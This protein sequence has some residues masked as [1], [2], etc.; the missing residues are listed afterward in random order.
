[1]PAEVLAE[2]DR[3]QCA[4][5]HVLDPGKEELAGR[6][7]RRVQ[8]MFDDGLVQEVER[9]RQLGFGGADVVMQGIGYQEAGA[10]LDGQLT[11]EEAVDQAIVR[12]RQYAKRQRTYFRG[13]GWTE[14]NEQDI[15][16]ATVRNP[17]D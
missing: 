1:L 6:I 7:E 9:L 4:G 3:W 11:V 17:A 12:T 13:Q 8:A 10:V 15:L 14:A 2:L 5:V 16:L